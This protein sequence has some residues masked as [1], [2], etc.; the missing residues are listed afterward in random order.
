[1]QLRTFKFSKHLNGLGSIAEMRMQLRSIISL[2][3]F[4]LLKNC[5][6]GYADLQLQNNI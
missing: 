5:D 3:S 6:C 2:K 4:G 1:M